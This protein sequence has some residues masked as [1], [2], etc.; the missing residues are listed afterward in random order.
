[1]AASARGPAGGAVAVAPRLSPHLPQSVA[2]RLDDRTDQHVYDSVPDSP[3]LCP[4]FMAAPFGSIVP[5][6]KA[7]RSNLLLMLQ[8]SVRA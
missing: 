5:P 4:A 2:I 1:M 8:V 7:L 3:K 6:S